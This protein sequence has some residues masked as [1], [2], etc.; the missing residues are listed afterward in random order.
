MALLKHKLPMASLSVATLV[1]FFVATLTAVGVS[2][3]KQ[4]SCSIDAV[5][6]DAAGQVLKT[7]SKSSKEQCYLF[8]IGCRLRC[9]RW[10][11]H[12]RDRMSAAEKAGGTATA[13]FDYACRATKEGSD[14][15]DAA[16]LTFDLENGSLPLR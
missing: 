14:D 1:F 13:R 4:V 5:T 6:A 7:W 15:E 16:S 8:G 12:M 11:G 2:G 10:C 3:A 9:E